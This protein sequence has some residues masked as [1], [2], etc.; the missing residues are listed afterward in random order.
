MAKLNTAFCY[1]FGSQGNWFPKDPKLSYNTQKNTET[2]NPEIC[3]LTYD[4]LDIVH[5]RAHTQIC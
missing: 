3:E 2:E 5:I 1:I 4:I